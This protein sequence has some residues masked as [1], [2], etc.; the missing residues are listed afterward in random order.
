MSEKCEKC[1]HIRYEGD[2]FDGRCDECEAWAQL[3]IAA[4]RERVEV[5]DGALRLSQEWTDTMID[6]C[7][8][9]LE[10]H[11][12]NTDR[13]NPERFVSFMLESLD[14]P[15]QRKAYEAARAALA[16]GGKEG[17]DA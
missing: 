14:G 9:Y 12:A 7:G 4:L 8:R 5:L 1:G 17:E 10:S 15:A 2:Q 11:P 3:E 6:Y 13:Y 16:G